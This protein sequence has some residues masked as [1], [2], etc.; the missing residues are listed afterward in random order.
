MLVGWIDLHYYAEIA[1]FPMCWRNHKKSQRGSALQM[2][3]GGICIFMH[4]LPNF[5]CVKENTATRKVKL[6]LVR[7]KRKFWMYRNT[8]SSFYI[9]GKKSMQMLGG[10]ICIMQK[11]PNSSCTCWAS[12]NITATRKCQIYLI[13]MNRAYL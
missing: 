1:N 4:E 12:E 3:G 2:L 13:Q 9:N 8:M 6:N 10:G 5:R 11:L 7:V